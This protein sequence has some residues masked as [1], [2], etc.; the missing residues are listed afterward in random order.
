MT[1][2][3]ED[4]K[5]RKKPGEVWTYGYK[6]TPAFLDAYSRAKLGMVYRNGLVSG[7]MF[8][9]DLEMF[10]FFNHA[11]FPTPIPRS[12]HLWRAC[13]IRWPEKNKPDDVFMRNPWAEEIFEAISNN[14]LIKLMGGSGQGKTKILCAFSVLA[15]DYFLLT[16]EGCR[17]IIT[18]VE[19][20]KLRGAAWSH[21][22]SLYRNQVDED[23]G[24]ERIF[25]Y[26]AGKGKEMDLKIKRP[27]PFNRDE[28]GN[29][30]GVLLSSGFQAD[31]GIKLVDKLTGSHVHTCAIII[32]DEIQSTPLAPI[33]ASF[34]LF[35]HPEHWWFFG[36]GNP[37]DPLDAI[38]KL[39]EPIDGWRSVDPT[40]LPDPPRHWNSV[41]DNGRTSHVIRFDNL[42]SPGFKHPKKYHYMPGQSMIDKSFRSESSRNSPAWWRFMRGWF[43]PNSSTQSLLSLLL[44]EETGC[45]KVARI[46]RD[47]I[48]KGVLSFDS[49]PASLDEAPFLH[50]ELIQESNAQYYINIVKYHLVPKTQ[51]ENFW[52]LAEDM[53]W[54]LCR[55]LRIESGGFISDESGNQSEMRSR[56]T[57]KDF[58]MLGLVYNEKPSDLIIDAVT[59]EIASNVCTNKISEAAILCRN[60]VRYG[61][62]RGLSRYL[63]E[64]FQKEFCTRKLLQKASGKFF[65]EPKDSFNAPNSKGG[66]ERESGFRSRMGFS[67]DK[68]DCLFQLAWYARAMWGMYPGI[69][70]VNQKIAEDRQKRGEPSSRTRVRSIHAREYLSYG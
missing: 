54:G 63:T 23:S 7:V 51:K 62:F 57:A 42:D 13:A 61:Q 68:L 55:D 49:A 19:E 28:R 5:A 27:S 69:N 50:A 12:E 66:I 18:S 9:Y 45:D 48:S 36:A 38:G 64:E 33:D 16:R 3:Y 25:S 34:N 39:F 40:V 46:A 35:T 53:F 60:F 70:I 43:L 56:L 15:F 37:S 52:R 58:H 17:V 2:T 44:I 47:F 41:D 10:F 29:M 22:T 8:Q 14:N 26:T 1:D 67:P 4:Y 24:Q 32:I 21:V 59:G 20:G 6:A 11:R 31:G 30:L 65:I